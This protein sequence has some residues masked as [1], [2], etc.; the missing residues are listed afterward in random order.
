MV[1]KA[2]TPADAIHLRDGILRFSLTDYFDLPGSSF[3]NI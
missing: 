3:S 2:D 1:F